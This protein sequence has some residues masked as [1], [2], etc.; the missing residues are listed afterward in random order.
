MK[1]S[2]A[3]IYEID[4]LKY[5]AFCLQ[6]N[7]WI[8][9]VVTCAQ[10]NKRVSA[11]KIYPNLYHK[12]TLSRG[13]FR[14][15]LGLHATTCC[16]IFAIKFSFLCKMQTTDFTTKL[17]SEH[18]DMTAPLCLPQIL[19]Y[20]LF[21]KIVQ[22]NTSWN[23]CL[24]LNYLLYYPFFLEKHSQL[25]SARAYHNILIMKHNE[26]TYEIIFSRWKIEH[27]QSVSLM[28]KE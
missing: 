2:A 26:V 4:Y 1:F 7:G 19:E 10:R 25:Q 8:T 6:I 11:K 3:I 13:N 28:G 15:Q 12:E 17:P 5:C 20:K 14:K 9:T 22:F 16:S 21:F 27:V 23:A 24:G 18:V